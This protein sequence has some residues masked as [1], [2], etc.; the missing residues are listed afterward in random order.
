M[1]PECLEDFGERAHGGDRLG[2]FLPQQATL[3][4]ERFAEQRLRFDEAALVQINQAELALDLES[5]RV[6]RAQQA[7]MNIERFGQMTLGGRESAQ[8]DIRAADR[9]VDGRRDFGL[10]GQFVVDALRGCVKDFAD[11]KLAAL[12]EAGI[13]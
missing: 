8:V 4:F 12:R 6:F 3:V 11:S 10:V 5:V 1:T 13:G 2:M 7:A 9:R